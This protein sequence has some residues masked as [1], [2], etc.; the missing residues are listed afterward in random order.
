MQRAIELAR[1]SVAEGGGPFG[2][3]VARAG[4]ILATGKNRVTLDGDPT[5]H[6]EVVAIRA[7]ARSLGAFD[8]TGCEVFASC[9][10]CP[11]C[12]GACL[13][14]RVDRVWFAATRDDAAAAGFDDAHLYAELRRPRAERETPLVQLLPEESLTAFRDWHAKPDRRA[15]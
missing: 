10:P 3:V 13:W 12:M 11:M 2:A 1:T 8:L 9:E 5:A 6:A 4:E 15:Y 7:A 14:A